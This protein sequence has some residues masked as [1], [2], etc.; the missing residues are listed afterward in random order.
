M[1]TIGKILSN[2]PVVR[3]VTIYINNIINFKILILLNMVNIQNTLSR[4]QRNANSKIKQQ[5]LEMVPKNLKKTFLKPKMNQDL[6]E[7]IY[8]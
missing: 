1:S 6:K 2:P 8:Y 4:F 5:I 3:H 7:N